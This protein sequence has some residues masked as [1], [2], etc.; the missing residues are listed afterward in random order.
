MC[1]EEGG[2]GAL[3]KREKEW[4][5]WRR[6]GEEQVGGIDWIAMGDLTLNAT[7]DLYMHTHSSIISTSLSLKFKILYT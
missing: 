4:E 1:E 7:I 5:A 6:A 3:A 2:V